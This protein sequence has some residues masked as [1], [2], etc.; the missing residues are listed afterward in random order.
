MFWTVVVVLALMVIAFVFGKRS[1][2][3]VLKEKVDACYRVAAKEPVVE[4]VPFMEVLRSVPRYMETRR[5]KIVAVA[6]LALV[7]AAATLSKTGPWLGKHLGATVPDGHIGF[8]VDSDGYPTVI[9]PLRPGWHPLWPGERLRLVDCAH[10]SQELLE[11]AAVTSDDISVKISV[12]VN[13]MLDCQQ[14]FDMRE[15]AVLEANG[16]ATAHDGWTRVVGPAVAERY[17]DYVSHL[18]AREVRENQALLRGYARDLVGESHTIDADVVGVGVSVST[19]EPE[20]SEPPRPEF[21]SVEMPQLR[22]W[23]RVRDSV[24]NEITYVRPR[25]TQSITLRECQSRQNDVRRAVEPHMSEVTYEHGRVTDHQ[26]FVADRGRCV[27]ANGYWRN[28]RSRSL[29][30]MELTRSLAR[31]A[32]SQL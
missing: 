7:V 13:A 14:E 29:E 8:T 16:Y 17:R 11:V 25:L 32:L 10:R 28:D 24:H 3:M 20:S 2:R 4:D 26:V 22:G 23:R 12:D 6:L 21:I 31:E 9:Y 18:T 15:L 30:M 5:Y 27:A 1:V 19:T